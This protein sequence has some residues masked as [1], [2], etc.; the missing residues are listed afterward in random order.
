ML[1]LLEHDE[2]LATLSRFSVEPYSLQKLFAFRHA[3]GGV[4]RCSYFL[5]FFMRGY[6]HCADTA[7]DAKRPT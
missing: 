5:K 3:T 7:L 1:V 4:R 6:G 2:I